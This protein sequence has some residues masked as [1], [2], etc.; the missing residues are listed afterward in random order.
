MQLKDVVENLK[1]GD[2]VWVRTEITDIGDQNMPMNNRHFGL[3]AS[4]M[5]TLLG[6]DVYG[7]PEV[8]LGELI[9]TTLDT[10]HQNSLGK[11]AAYEKILLGKKITI[12]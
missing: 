6:A 12:E 11:I 7:G 8:V 3:T 9:T 2:V 4:L 1:V 5:S 10:K